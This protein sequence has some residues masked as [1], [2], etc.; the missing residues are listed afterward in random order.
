VRILLRWA[1][2]RARRRSY[3]PPPREN[4]VDVVPTD[5]APSTHAAVTELESNVS[6]VSVTSSGVRIVDKRR[7]T[8]DHTTA[9]PE[10]DAGPSD[11]TVGPS[12]K[13]QFAVFYRLL[14]RLITIG[15][16]GPLP[17]ETTSE[18]LGVLAW[19]DG[20]CRAVLLD[21]KGATDN[22]LQGTI[23]ALITR[24]D[25]GDWRAPVRRWTERHLATSELVDLLRSTLF[26]NN[27]ASVDDRLL[28]LCLRLSGRAAASL[29]DDIARDVLTLALQVAARPEDPYQRQAP[30]LVARGAVV[31]LLRGRPDLDPLIHH[32]VSI[33]RPAE[34]S[35]TASEEAG[36]LAI[37]IR[38]RAPDGGGSF[39]E[40]AVAAGLSAAGLDSLARQADAPLRRPARVRHVEVPGPISSVVGVFRRWLVPWLLPPILA[41]TS[42]AMTAHWSWRGPPTSVGLSD[43]IVA[44]TLLA[45]VN[46]FT[47]QLS[48]QR[49]PGIVARTAGQPAALYASYASVL[50]VLVTTLIRP[51]SASAVAATQWASM[52]GLV[53]FVATLLVAMFALLRRTD[54]ARAA[55]GFVDSTL[56]KARTAGRK[57]GRIQ[58]R[59]V[60]LR[61]TLTGV[62]AVRM[63]ADS[64]AGEWSEAITVR[65]RGFFLPTRR[66]LR[67]LL[68]LSQFAEGMR[69]R[70]VAG[71]GTIVNEGS[72]L[73]FLVPATT[74]T[75]SGRLARRT[76]RTLGTTQARRVEETA[77]GVVALAKLALDLAASG[78]RGTAHTVA[79]NAN[80]LVAAHVSSAQAA[81]RANLRWFARMQSARAQG[82][83]R[84]YDGTSSEVRR[85]SDDD[86]IVP[87]VP[88]I[89]DVLQ[90]VVGAR[91]NA[92]SELREVPEVMISALLA[93]SGRAEAAA[94]MVITAIPDSATD[95]KSSSAAVTELLRLAAVRTLET[96]DAIV[97][98]MVIDKLATLASTNSHNRRYLSDSVGTCSVLGAIACRFE[99]RRAKEAVDAVVAMLDLARASGASTTATG[100]MQMFGLW[101]IGAASLV[102]GSPSVAVHVARTLSAG[103]QHDLL[104]AAAKDR[105]TLT[106]EAAQSTIRGG[107]LG[108]NG[109]DALANFG[110]FVGTI[111]SQLVPATPAATQPPPPAP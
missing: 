104:V 16:Q 71:L 107:Y 96:N 70:V 72:D 40:L 60:Y 93:A 5:D 99:S 110:T 63:A 87:V 111:Q 91:V 56:I 47:V 46:V 15:L 22:P 90:L 78:D 29:P 39:Q 36:L 75:V 101:R 3:Q 95:M 65:A 57:L 20:A 102:T 26:E 13:A 53:L 45:S 79:Q 37:A 59:A 33:T 62:P 51:R 34:P 31:E 43:A 44:L 67:S 32:R 19:T 80:R 4:S 66:E 69:L 77:S 58:G 83:G 1:D 85:L 25:I 50:T 92:L 10:S 8:T 54:A 18:A 38:D 109:M 27:L 52:A 17:T 105:D 49:L 73:A 30:Q 88:A 24:T 42:G 48:A 9:G 68:S 103:G 11:T 35:D 21:S 41:V 23:L 2:R 7:Q 55:Q 86:E 94:V 6:P 28:V 108:D 89:R 12:G 14:G 64:V 82:D 97:F 106:R 61:T 98:R 74:Q 81:R 100:Q 84:P 76:S